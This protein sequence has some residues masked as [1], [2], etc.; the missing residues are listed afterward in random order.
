MFTTKHNFLKAR[1][2]A[3]E[4]KVQA[5]IDIIEV[6][7]TQRK[8]AA[9]DM[10]K[11][12]FSLGLLYKQIDSLDKAAAAFKI[13]TVADYAFVGYEEYTNIQKILKFRKSIS[14]N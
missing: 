11:Y 13:A 7:V 3:K 1:A 9:D 14:K 10:L 8:Y 4:G 12:N 6:M 5:A 2:L